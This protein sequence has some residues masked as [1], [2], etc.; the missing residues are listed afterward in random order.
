[1]VVFGGEIQLDSQNSDNNNNNNNNNNPNT[2]LPVVVKVARNDETTFY[3]NNEV[4]IL[5]LLQQQQDCSSYIPE[6][7]LYFPVEETVRYTTVL[8][9]APLGIALDQYVNCR[10]DRSK[11]SSK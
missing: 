1:M 5:N 8:V 11:H 10:F 9:E 4:K 3:L 2:N 7:K 6:V